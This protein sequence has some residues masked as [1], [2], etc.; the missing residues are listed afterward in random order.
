LS[1]GE[2]EVVCIKL[3]ALGDLL[4]DEQVLQVA[5]KFH[6]ILRQRRTIR[7]KHPLRTAVHSD[8]MDLPPN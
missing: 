1:D 3:D 2:F 4:C 8:E 6:N 5:D 7:A